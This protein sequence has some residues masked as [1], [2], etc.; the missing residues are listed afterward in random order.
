MYKIFLV[1]IL[2]NS[3]NASY[4]PII[5]SVD[6]KAIE[7]NNSTVEDNNSTISKEKIDYKSIFEIWNSILIY[8]YD[9][10]ILRDII[11]KRYNKGEDDPL[12]G[13]L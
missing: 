5:L 2:N 7:D 3:I 10:F 11:I 4:E 1:I 8:S 9:D 6:N 12:E 13:L